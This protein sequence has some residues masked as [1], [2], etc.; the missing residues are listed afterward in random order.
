[1]Y[2][3]IRKENAKIFSIADTT[4]LQLA[5]LYL[6]FTFRSQKTFRE[7]TV[8]FNKIFDRKSLALVYSL[9]TVSSCR[10]QTSHFAL[11]FPTKIV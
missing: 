9:N 3:F 11:P 8:C 7:L 2:N 5:S 6:I 1:M 10:R 4:E